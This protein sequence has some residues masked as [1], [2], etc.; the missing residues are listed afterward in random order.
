MIWS[1][2]FDLESVALPCNSEIHIMVGKVL[3]CA[4]HCISTQQYQ[5]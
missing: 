4:F 3:P 2:D 5:V 1:P